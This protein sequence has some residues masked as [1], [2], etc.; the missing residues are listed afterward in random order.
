K[1][2]AP[3]KTIGDQLIR[4]A[5][6]VPANLAEGHGRSGRDRLHHYRIAYASAKEVDVHLRLL[7]LSHH[8]QRGNATTALQLFDDVRAMTWRLIH[9][10]K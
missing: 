10:T 9:P 5:S 4:S 6:S 7:C 3:L 1:V 8:S 2:P